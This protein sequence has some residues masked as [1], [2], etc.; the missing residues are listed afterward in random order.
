MRARQTHDAR[1]LAHS[2]IASDNVGELAQQRLDALH[3][4]LRSQ[5]L[6]E[7]PIGMHTAARRHRDARQDAVSGT[8]FLIIEITSALERDDLVQRL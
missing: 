8:A 4:L 1:D 7:Q 6:L 3:V 5:R 2:E